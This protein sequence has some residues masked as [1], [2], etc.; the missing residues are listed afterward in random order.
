LL[1]NLVFNEF[2]TEEFEESLMQIGRHLG[3]KTQRPEKEKTAKLDVLWT[4]G[5]LQFILFPCK[6]GA[7]AERISKNYAD[8]ASGNMQWFS[9][10]YGSECNGTP[11]IVH[12]STVLDTDAYAPSTTRVMDKALM[13]KFR[14]AIIA[15]A[16]GVK[17]SLNSVSQIKANLS[18]NKLLGEQFLEAFTVP[19]MKSK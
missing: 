12:P 15:F 11:V 7:V 13:T 2:G 17:D 4:I 14:S 1:E 9:Q 16:S 6:S 18:A 5:G 10:T 3:F 19:V 8:Q